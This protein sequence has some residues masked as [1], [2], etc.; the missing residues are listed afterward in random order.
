MASSSSPSNLSAIFPNSSSFNP[1]ITPLFPTS[2]SYFNK[3]YRKNELRRPSSL[4]CSAAKQQTGPV[5]KRTSPNSTKKKKKPIS[6]FETD[7]AQIDVEV[8]E[9][10]VQSSERYHPLPLPKPPAGFVLDEQGRV[11]MASNKRIATIVSFFPLFT[12]ISC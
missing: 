7:G 10:G 3:K 11:L 4:S 6:N 8:E 1:Q 12:D 5:K 2:S 9:K